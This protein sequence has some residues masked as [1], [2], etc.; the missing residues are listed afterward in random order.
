MKTTP[1]TTAGTPANKSFTRH[2]PTVARILMGVPLV[3][4]GLNAFFNFIPPP[5]TP[6]PEGAMAFA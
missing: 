6:L 1:N 2:F 3:I 4:F 5:S